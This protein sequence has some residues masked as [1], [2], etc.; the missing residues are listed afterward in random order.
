MLVVLRLAFS[1]DDI[2]Q[3]CTGCET[4]AGVVYLSIRVDGRD[5]DGVLVVCQ[6]NCLLSA[7]LRAAC[8]N[9]FESKTH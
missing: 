2:F 3:S 6:V 5:T 8:S 4:G 1:R 7:Q 9:A